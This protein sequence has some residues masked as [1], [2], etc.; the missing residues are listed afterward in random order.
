[1]VSTE[2]MPAKPRFVSKSIGEVE[3]DPKR[4]LFDPAILALKA[5]EEELECLKLEEAMY[6]E[7]LA[8]EQLEMELREVQQEEKSLLNST[9]PASSDV[10]P[11]ALLAY[12]YIYMYVYI[13]I[14]Y[15]LLL[16]LGPLYV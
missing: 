1:M 9:I 16:L 2:K 11:S 4:K 7:L 15:Y 3:A 12:I 14:F 6:E 13:Y 8:Q 10:A 5:A